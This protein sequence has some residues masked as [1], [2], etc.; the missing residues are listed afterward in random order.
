[1]FK[2]QK[3]DLKM[4]FSQFKFAHSNFQVMFEITQ[5]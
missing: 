1:M 5:L 3:K 4:F 2:E